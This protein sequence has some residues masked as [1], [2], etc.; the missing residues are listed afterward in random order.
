MDP[1]FS[2]QEEKFKKNFF[3]VSLAFILSVFVFGMIFLSSC[4]SIDEIAKDIEELIEIDD[5]T[6]PIADDIA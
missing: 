4:H 6:D 1:S 5:L 3:L 2:S